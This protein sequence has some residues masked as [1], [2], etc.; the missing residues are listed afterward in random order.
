MI[1]FSLIVVSF[2]LGMLLIGQVMTYCE[3]KGMVNP[4]IDRSSHIKPTVRGGGLTFVLMIVPF[5][6]FYLATLESASLSVANEP[7]LWT[8]ICMSAVVAFVGWKDDQ[9]GLNPI[10]RILVQASAISLCVYHLPAIVPD[11]LPLYAE[12]I[13][14]VLGWLWFVNLYNFMDGIDGFA[15]C[16]AVFLAIILSLICADIKPIMLVLSGA[17]L[18]ILRLNFPPAKIFLG[19]VGSTFL[20]FLLGGCLIYTL[21]VMGT[22]S[23]F[24]LLTLTL[25]FT[26]DA[27][28]TLIRRTVAGHKPWIAHREHFYQRAYHKVGFS[29][30]DIV[31]RGMVINFVLMILAFLG[32]GLH[33]GILMFAL[34]LVLLATVAFRIK[35]LEGNKR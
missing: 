15:T 12:K 28:Y 31:A 9:K 17:G 13:L 8:L 34:A 26:A 6:L 27:T 10:V 30:K 22:E 2:I 24:P 25:L 33:N 20:G 3:K 19:D 23:L 35:R 16:E 29:H 18:G 1:D 5:A 32:L 21:C 4:V 7:F 11:L 14:L